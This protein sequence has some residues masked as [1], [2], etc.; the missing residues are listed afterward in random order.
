MIDPNKQYTVTK[1]KAE[2]KEIYV[3]QGYVIV[4]SIPFL[5]VGKVMYVDGNYPEGLRTSTVTEIFPIEKG[6]GVKT[7]NSTYTVVEN[8]PSNDN[9]ESNSTLD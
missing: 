8:V 7:L 4:G 1:V 9:S 2:Q 6:F 5:E 3:K